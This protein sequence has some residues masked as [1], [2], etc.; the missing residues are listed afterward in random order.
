MAVDRFLGNKRLNPFTGAVLF[1]QN[2]I[3]HLF[4]GHPQAPK[5]PLYSSRSYQY[6][7]FWELA[8][9]SLNNFFLTHGRNCCY[10]FIY[11]WINWGSLS[12]CE[13]P[14]SYC[15]SV[16]LHSANHVASTTVTTDRFSEAGQTLAIPR[17]QI[18][19]RNTSNF[20]WHWSCLRNGTE[21]S[22]YAY[23]HRHWLTRCWVLVRHR[24]YSEY[25]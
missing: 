9:F 7:W 17:C 5:N 10:F 15:C 13:S 1:W 14:Y 18:P 8:A 16:G 23:H 4:K 3:S 11:P 2:S 6:R 21:P 20:Q 19:A 22:S 24:S 25:A 12:V